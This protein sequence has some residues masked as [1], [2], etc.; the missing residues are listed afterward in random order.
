MLSCRYSLFVFF[1]M[2]RRP[3]R[4][5]RTST[6]FPYTTLFLAVLTKLFEM[7]SPWWTGLAAL[8]MVLF[9]GREIMAR[10]QRGFQP[11]CAYGIGTSAM[12]MA[13]TLVTIFALTTAVRP[14]PWYDPRY[15]LPLL[16]MILG[17]TDRKSTRLNSSH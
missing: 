16:G 5:T 15:A 13:A 1:L 14:D 8:A 7:A 12:L 2:I 10:Q 4:S 11:L 17:N 6:L 9:A 3:P